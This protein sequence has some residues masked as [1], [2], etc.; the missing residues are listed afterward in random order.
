[1]PAIVLPPSIPVEGNSKIWWVPTLADPNAPKLTELAAVSAVDITCYLTKD[2]SFKDAMEQA[3]YVDARACSAEET[4][5]FGAIKRSL[6]DLIYVY[7]PQAAA[8]A[9]DN[10]AEEKMVTGTTGYF[11]VRRGLPYQTAVAVGQFVSVVGATLGGRVEVG[12]ASN[13]V[14]K[15]RQKVSLSLPYVEKVA[16]A[17]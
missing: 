11:V 15:R 13:S 1:M 12:D 17:A 10:A 7:Q 8:L 2:G 3:T 5:L 9:A 16:L 14:Y 6:E 4:E